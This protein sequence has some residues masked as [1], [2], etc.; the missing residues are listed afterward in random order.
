M[1]V[2]CGTSPRTLWPRAGSLPVVLCSLALVASFAAL[3]PLCRSQD[4]G[5]KTL[6]GKVYDGQDATLQGAIV[7]LQNSRNNDVKTY[8]SANDGAYRF[9]AL[10]ADTDYTVWAVF[11]GK[12]SPTKAISS[13]D[14]RKQVYVDLHI[15]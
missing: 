12:R 13:F 8:I 10:S 9:A 14:S 7:Y 2:F 1:R 3:A 6:Q 15:K 11:K 5:L 4:F